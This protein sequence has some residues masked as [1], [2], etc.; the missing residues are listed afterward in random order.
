MYFTGSI[1]PA[2]DENTAQEGAEYQEID[3]AQFDN[4]EDDALSEIHQEADNEMHDLLGEEGDRVSRTDMLK[5]CTGF[6]MLLKQ[7]SKKS[8]NPAKILLAT[9]NAQ[10][11]KESSIRKALQSVKD[12]EPP[13]PMSR[14]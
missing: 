7:A 2:D 6:N 9:D 5:I 11:T 14:K 10:K 4:A 12:I 8:T 13:V 1:L 3:E